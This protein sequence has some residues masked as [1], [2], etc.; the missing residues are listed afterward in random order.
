[1]L[2]IHHAPGTR[3]FRVIWLCEELGTPYQVVPVDMSP[4]YRA[5]PEWRKLNPVGKVPVMSDGALTIFESGAMVQYVLEKY[6]KGRLQPAH[7]SDDYGIYL[8]WC[9]FAEATFGRALGEIVN[10]R[11]EFKDNPLQNV[12]D[13]MKSRSRLAADAVSQALTDKTWIIGKEFSAA[14]V[15]LGLTLR[16]YLKHMGEELPGNLAPYWSRLTARSAYKNAAA[17]ESGKAK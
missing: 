1:M 12:I 5:S 2:K 16:S 9:W 10:H 11:R 13:E 6:G 15:M 14:D 8:Q 3:G 17:A 4:A 7:D